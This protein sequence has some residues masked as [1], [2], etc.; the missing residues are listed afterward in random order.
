MLFL[1]QLAHDPV[2]IMIIYKRVKFHTFVDAAVFIK[3][4]PDSMCNFKIIVIIVSGIK[5]FMELIVGNAVEHLLS[6]LDIA[7]VVSMDH[8]SHK[9]EIFFFSDVRR[10]ISSMK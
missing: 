2:Y 7:A 9:P 8:F 10:R 6:V 3:F 5:T 1:V 4:S